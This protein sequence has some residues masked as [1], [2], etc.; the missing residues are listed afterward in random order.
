MLL[1]CMGIVIGL[2]VVVFGIFGLWASSLFGGKA[3]FWQ[4]WVSFNKVKGM[5]AAV[6][7]F[8]NF[9]IEALRMDWPGVIL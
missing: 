2:E 1:G 9:L 7:F 4:Y 8:C 5:G 6:F 3:C